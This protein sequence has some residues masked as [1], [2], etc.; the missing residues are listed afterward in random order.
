M[1]KIKAL[2]TAGPT[3]EYLDPIRYLSNAS[4]G[5][6]GLSVARALKKRGVSV[7]LVLG[8]GV[9]A[10]RGI[11]GFRAGSARDMFGLVKRN[12]EWCD[13]F[14]S[15]AAVADYRPDTVSRKKIKKTSASRTLKLVPNPDIL[16]EMGRRKGGRF[17]AGFALEDSG[18]F[19]EARRKMKLKNCDLMVLNGPDT[20]DADR[21]SAAL[22]SP[23]RKP[24]KL[25][26][27]SKEK[28][29]QKLCQEI[30]SS[31]KPSKNM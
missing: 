23:D 1:R 4:S 22:L 12:F 18:G 3:R 14:I 15:C 28:F 30:L 27:M 26:K 6:T 19:N 8:P 16:R 29:A 24:L 7:R 21:I 2:V 31:L 10:P 9:D 17:L 5:R 13:V 25:G 11:P 20:V